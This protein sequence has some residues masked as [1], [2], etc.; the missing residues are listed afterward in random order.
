MNF[1]EPKLEKLYSQ[2]KIT[3]RYFDTN[4]YKLFKDSINYDVDKFK[5]RFRK[6]SDS[7]VIFKE[8]KENTTL[9]KF[10]QT[11]AT[12]Y[13]NL[14]EINSTLHN[15]LLLFP[16]LDI[17]YTRDYFKLD[18]VRLT[19]D[20]RINFKNTQNRSSHLTKKYFH[21]NIVEYKILNYN[22]TEIENNIPLNTINFSKYVF[23]VQKI[24]NFI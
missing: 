23:G 1:Y 20:K 24:Y 12:T 2:R 16:S 22:N 13:K 4:D 11:D 6:Y 9:G 7:K 15:K 18:N 10:K 17:E 5:V 8:I 14:E 21:K 19:I 3:S